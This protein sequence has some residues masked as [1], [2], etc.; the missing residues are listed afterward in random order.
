MCPCVNVPSIITHECAGFVF[1]NI[2]GAGSKAME[3]F[4]QTI[5]SRLEDGGGEVT[6]MSRVSDFESGGTWNSVPLLPQC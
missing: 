6:A 1:I 4:I 5:R 2:S 3:G